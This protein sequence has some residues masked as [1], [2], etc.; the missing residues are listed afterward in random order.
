MLKGSKLSMRVLSLIISIFLLCGSSFAADLKC[1][2]PYSVIKKMDS[3]MRG[4]TSYSEMEMQVVTKRWKRTVKMKSWSE[5]SKKSFIIITYPRKD[6]G[7][8]FLRVGYDMWQYVP[9]IERVI[10][11]PPSMMLQ[12]WMGSDF[13]NDDLVRESSVVNDYI[14]KFISENNGICRFEL[15]PKENAPVVWG[16]I[17]FYVNIE[18]LMPERAVYYDENGL[19]VR[20]LSYEE[21]RK[22]G[23]RYYP[24]KWVLKPLEEDKKGRKTIITVNKIEFDKKL[25][26]DIFSIKSLKRFSR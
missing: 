19:A 12:S 18:K 7:V 14:Q 15:I 13:T 8:T 1:S 4:L 24:Y 25:E 11:I 5:G 21:I 22:A 3:L 23:D 26:K 10:K 17:E 16:K 9:R 20:D 2:D 6:Q